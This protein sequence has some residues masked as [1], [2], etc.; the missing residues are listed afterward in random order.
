MDKFVTATGCGATGAM[1]YYDGSNIPYY[2][3]YANKYVLDDN[4][5]SSLPGP[6]FPNHL[7]IMSGNNKPV[8]GSYIWVLNGGV[9]NNPGV[10]NL[11]TLGF[12]FSWRPLAQELSKAK[13]PWAVYTGD[14]DPTQPSTD[15][16]NKKLP[17]ISW[18][19]PGAWTP[20]SPPWPSG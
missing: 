8:S 9:T 14:A 18:I 4:F 1:G 10:D 5:F 6:E 20:P 15:I 3:D 2:W 19:F 11:S 7:Y 16:Q 17:A 13:V 12:S